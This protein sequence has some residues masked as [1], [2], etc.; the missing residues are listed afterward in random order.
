[1]PTDSADGPGIVV[2]ADLPASVQSLWARAGRRVERGEELVTLESMKMEIPVQA[3]VDGVVSVTY[4]AAGDT[5]AM[6]APLM[7]I[8]ASTSEPQEGSAGADGSA[9]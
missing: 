6:G 1:M 4:V 5:V 8:V 7:R 3:P 2:H 9:H